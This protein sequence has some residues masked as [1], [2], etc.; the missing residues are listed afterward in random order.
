MEARLQSERDNLKEAMN[1]VSGFKATMSS[2][3]VGSGAS[4]NNHKK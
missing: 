3:T 1:S 4:L 2:G